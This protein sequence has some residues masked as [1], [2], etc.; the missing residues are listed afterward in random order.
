MC[1]NFFWFMW[2]KYF[3]PGVKSDRVPLRCTAKHGS[4]APPTISGYGQQRA[5]SH[6]TAQW[7]RG[8]SSSAGENAR[9]PETEMCLHL[10]KRASV[11]K[12]LCKATK[13]SEGFTVR[14]CVCCFL[15]CSCECLLVQ[16]HSRWLLR[17]LN[18]A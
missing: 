17:H 4:T 7:K 12:T 15:I 6:C 16:T 18:K 11:F 9:R 8:F 13:H 1:M 2:V 10:V 5:R 14:L 3:S